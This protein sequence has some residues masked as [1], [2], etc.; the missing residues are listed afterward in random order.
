MSIRILPVITES[1]KELPIYLVD[2]A[3]SWNQEH[4]RRESGFQFQWIQCVAGEGEL[5][6]SDKVYRIKEGMAFLLLENEF[7]EY[8]AKSP[9]WIVDWVLFN[10]SQVS[11]FLSR[12]CGFHSSG[13][14]YLKDPDA[15]RSRIHSLF[16]IKNRN[17]TLRG[18]QYSSI[19]YSLLTDIAQYASAN[20]G[21][22]N[23]SHNLRLEPLFQYIEENLHRPLTLDELAGVAGI[24]P[25]YLCAIFKKTTNVRVFQYI[26]SVRI[27]KS[28]ELLLKHPAMPI[29]EVAG[30]SGF[31]DANYFCS[32]FRRLVQLSP[33]QFRRLYY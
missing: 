16:N 30:L 1:D 13:A 28:K 14:F 20:P 6:T 31:E 5:I 2:A 7:H 29:Q 18:M 15:I 22:S 10:G 3:C 9:E 26:N 8:F 32:V 27:R 12:N 19:L 17:D 21:A 11:A 23:A 4:I 33:G 25:E 24:T